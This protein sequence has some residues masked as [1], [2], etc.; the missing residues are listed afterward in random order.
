MPDASS[1]TVYIQQEDL[2]FAQLTVVE[3]LDTSA[4]LRSSSSR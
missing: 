2:L 1:K 3:T 4:A